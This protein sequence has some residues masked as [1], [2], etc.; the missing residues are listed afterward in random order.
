MRVRK[1]F[2]YSD[3]ENFFFFLSVLKIGVFT[4]FLVN[5]NSVRGEGFH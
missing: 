1:I 2:K 4:E 5:Y 3:F